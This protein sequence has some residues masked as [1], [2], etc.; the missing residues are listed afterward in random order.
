MRRL[1]V[2]L[3]VGGKATKCNLSLQ[4]PLKSQLFTTLNFAFQSKIDTHRAK[5]LHFL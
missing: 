2:G 5:M 1:C 3:T 4:M